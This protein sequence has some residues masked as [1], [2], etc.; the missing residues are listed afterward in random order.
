MSKGKLFVNNS[1]EIRIKVGKGHFYFDRFVDSMV[2]ENNH[3][4][5]E[6]KIE[7]AEELFGKTG[8]NN[9]FAISKKDASR[10]ATVLNRD[11]SD[12]V[13]SEFK[14]GISDQSYQAIST[15]TSKN[16][17]MWLNAGYQTLSP[18][19]SRFESLFEMTKS[20]SSFVYLM[21]IEAGGYTKPVN[22]VPFLVGDARSLYDGSKIVKDIKGAQKQLV[23]ADLKEINK[24]YSA[25]RKATSEKK[26]NFVIAP[27]KENPNMVKVNNKGVVVETNEILT[28]CIDY[29]E[30]LRK[31]KS[32]KAKGKLSNATTNE[33]TKALAFS[34]KLPKVNPPIIE[35]KN[36]YE[37]SNVA[38]EQKEKGN[39]FRATDQ[40][41]GFLGPFISKSDLKTI[42]PIMKENRSVYKDS[43]LTKGRGILEHLMNEG[44]E[45]KLTMNPEYPEQLIAELQDGSGAK[46]RLLDS[47]ENENLV[48]RVHTNE[49][50]FYFSN[51]GGSLNKQ[52]ENPFAII[53]YVTGSSKDNV[54][55]SEPTKSKR[56]SSFIHLKDSSVPILFIPIANK[57]DA[58]SFKSVAAA[59]MAMKEDID[60]ARALFRE[61]LLNEDEDLY[62]EDIA[63]LQNEYKTVLAKLDESLLEE[64]KKNP[65]IDYEM[66]LEETRENLIGRLLDAEIGN[67][68]D[69]FHLGRVNELNRKI[70]SYS[71]TERLLSAMKIV[72]YDVENKVRGT[73]FATQTLVDRMIRFNPATSLAKDDKKLSPYYK[74]IVKEVEAELK[75]QGILGYDSKTREVKGNE[76]PSVRIDA[77]GIVRWGGYRVKGSSTN[78]PELEFVSSDIG[79]FFEP[80]SNG[81]IQT[82][83][84]SGENYG[85]I[86]GYRG[87][88]QFADIDKSRMERNRVYGLD[89]LVKRKIRTT[90]RE[91]AVRPVSEISNA[92]L[93]SK[94]A[95]SVN[96]LYQTDLAGE[97]V[98]DKW[99]ENAQL[100]LEEKKVIIE[101]AKRRVRFSSL[102]SDHASTI[103]VSKLENSPNTLSN[104]ERTVLQLNGDKN[105]RQ[106]TED[107]YG[108]YDPVMTGTNTIQGLAL[109]LAKDAKIDAET[110]KITPAPYDAT[111]KDAFK[112]APATSL[113]ELDYFKYS[114]HNPWDR[115]QMAA[116]QLTTAFSV[117][118]ARTALMTFGGWNME[119]GFV[120]SKEFADRNLVPDAETGEM[121]PLKRGDKLSDFG[122]NKGT[123][124]LIV[125]RNMSPEE[126]KKQDLVREVGIMKA[127]PD[128]DVVG[129]PYAMISRHNAGVIKEMQDGEVKP[130][131]DEN[132]EIIAESGTLNMIVT[133][134]QADKKSQTYS[135]DDL[136]EG[137]GRKFS[138]QLIWTMNE[139]GADN[140]V[141]E[142]F[143]HND[144]SWEILREYL[145]ATGFDMEANGTLRKGYKPHGAEVRNEFEVKQEVQREDF[146]KEINV[147]GGMLNLPFKLKMASGEKTNQLPI[148]DASTRSTTLLID[149]QKKDHRYTL[150][151]ADVYEEALLYKE[152]QASNNQKDMKKHFLK[153]QNKLNVLQNSIA[154]DKLG[155]MSGET[156]KNSFFKNNLM[157]KRLP[158]T[159]TAVITSDPRLSIDTICV[160]PEIYKTLNIRG[161]EKV[162]IHR[163][164]CLREGAA[165]AFKVI[166]DKDISGI[167]MNPVV[168]KS[169]DADF[170]GDTMGIMKP[171]TKGAIEDLEF[172]LAIKHNLIDK[173]SEVETSYLNVSM[174]VISGAVKSGIVQP[175]KPRQ[176]KE[177]SP[178]AQVNDLF[179]KAA[180]LPPEQAVEETDKLVKMCLREGGFG[181][182]KVMIST[183][184]EM[185]SSL[186]AMVNDGAKG[187][188][189]GVEAFMRY[190]DDKATLQ[191]ILD[192]QGATGAKSDLTGVAG[193]FSQKLMKTLRDT[194][195]TIALESTYVITQ[196]TLQIKHDAELGRE[197]PQILLVELKDLLN[198][199]NRHDEESPLTKEDFKEGM[200][201]VYN[202][203]LNVDIKEESL[204]ELSN[205]LSEDG[206]TIAGV[207]K[208]ATKLASPMDQIT[209]NGGLKAISSLAE[210]GR[211]LAEGEKSALIVP[212]KILEADEYTIIAK[213]GT[214]N[215]E[216]TAEKQK[217][218][219]PAKTVE[220]EKLE[221]RILE[222]KQSKEQDLSAE[223]QN[224]LKENEGFTTLEDD[225]LLF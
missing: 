174:D 81:I 180:K 178:K 57:M 171:Q 106:I 101:T 8:L 73:D 122:G 111:Q 65:S 30:N 27:Y 117:D 25:L 177:N 198:G 66:K 176:K 86:P 18:T 115:N 125:D 87:H 136:A 166:V 175:Y 143:S 20:D 37:K 19:D 93:L 204:E 70:N 188:K 110:G 47:D 45:Y 197:L 71:Q 119:D 103:A 61:Q 167:S 203:R 105:I 38:Q 17:D 134:M 76:A 191:D 46:V 53:D 116:N 104:M 28:N 160:S 40:V 99:F 84:S 114:K 146:L 158:N 170:D 148:L 68:E 223:A 147:K 43:I 149:E 205:L 150:M 74:E 100:S 184:K 200:R 217:T 192:V 21:H 88:F 85:I 139:H 6:E 163:D 218:F 26:T 5:R 138:S 64:V 82:K 42:L 89:T 220:A 35:F 169:F 80:D 140:I 225:I 161:D 126:A 69:G 56:K 207:D 112:N 7:V 31:Q 10:I 113:R 219:K 210:K 58:T 216:A 124:A 102:Y 172:K 12:K 144:N 221:E 24:H 33:K 141:K 39:K 48:G 3:L 164:P 62:D 41:T 155:G 11:Y 142:V 108:Y 189:K 16:F 151:Y 83:Y 130:V 215:K 51:K 196:G 36:K 79:Q 168:T 60:M 32:E 23:V 49:G 129:S 128:L 222:V 121:R 107:A 137:K 193:N 97:R 206:L 202:N 14:N 154:T 179:L 109:Y 34:R 132:G 199:V 209:Y 94:D 173:N 214:L 50:S 194:N 118:N 131:Y 213:K 2:N 133:D 145:I 195:P 201:H 165:R 156:S 183:K 78:E 63:K 52:P 162:M 72:R 98:N 44:I 91:Q 187:S 22:N 59:E 224:E 96:R 1:D 211:S 157:S 190:Y 159:A 67:Y 29:M 127:N 77:N 54:F 181:S 120:V 90:V 186:M 182:A 4:T 9:T 212:K 185:K 15:K 55:Y 95:T 135:A 92:I 123:I 208:I 75:A 153:A 13:S 152:A